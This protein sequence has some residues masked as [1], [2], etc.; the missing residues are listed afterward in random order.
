MISMHTYTYIYIYIT[1]LG[2]LPGS[3]RRAGIVQIIFDPE[4]TYS[5]QN[6]PGA[7]PSTAARG[8]SSSARAP[9]CASTG[10]PNLI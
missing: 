4:S 1:L 3:A 2:S 5:I 8:S 9:S 6:L 7:V 10:A